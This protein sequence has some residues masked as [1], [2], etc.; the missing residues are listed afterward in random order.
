MGASEA[1]AEVGEIVVALEEVAV[2]ETV[3]AEVGFR[4]SEYPLRET[5]SGSSRTWR[6][7]TPV[8]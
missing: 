3:E 6:N 7:R 4:S 1:E 8:W 2:V 5:A